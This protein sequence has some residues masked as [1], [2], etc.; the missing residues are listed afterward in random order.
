MARVSRLVAQHSCLLIFRALQLH[1]P[2][3]GLAQRFGS[4]WH[5]EPAPAAPPGSSGAA[6]TVHLR[7]RRRGDILRCSFGLV[8]SSE[9]PEAA[10]EI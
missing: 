3:S 1:A 6:C 7:V 10:V 9:A 4:F 8:T 2:P 5:D